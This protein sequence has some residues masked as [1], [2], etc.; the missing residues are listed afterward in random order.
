[1]HKRRYTM[2]WPVNFHFAESQSRLVKDNIWS[3]LYI[4]AF[5]PLAGAKD[6]WAY[7]NV[8][9]VT[10]I[11]WPFCPRRVSSLAV[12]IPPP[13]MHLARYLE[14]PCIANLL[15]RAIVLRVEVQKGLE[16]GQEGSGQQQKRKRSNSEGDKNLDSQAKILLSLKPSLGGAVSGLPKSLK[17]LNY[18]EN[19]QELKTGI[20]VSQTRT[21]NKETH[22]LKLFLKRCTY[23]GSSLWSNVY[24]GIL[25]TSSHLAR[26]SRFSTF[27]ASRPTCI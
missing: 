2:F 5:G 26:V 27:V 24:L 10:A 14:S 4:S 3:C 9:F 23:D 17:T 16:M 11:T 12:S 1:M 22:A 7:C 20:E 6:L 18:P 13:P 21:E 19:P 8:V 15:C 25:T